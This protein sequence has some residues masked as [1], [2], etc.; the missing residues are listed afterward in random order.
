MGLYT[1]IY[2]HQLHP[3]HTYAYKHVDTRSHT[4]T[5]QTH[6]KK[7]KEEKVGG[8]SSQTR[9]PHAPTVD[10]GM[11]FKGTLESSTPDSLLEAQSGLAHKLTSSCNK[12][13]G[14]LVLGCRDLLPRT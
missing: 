13:P 9:V 7:G 5:I 6:P 1:H 2:T 14:I 11:A 3:P 10:S 8:S 12:W 4:C